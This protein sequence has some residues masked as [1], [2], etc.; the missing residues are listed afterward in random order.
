[1]LL[2]FLGSPRCFQQSF[3]NRLARFK[4]SKGAER[5]LASRTK[6]QAMLQQVRLATPEINMAP[7]R[8][9]LFDA[10]DDSLRKRRDM[11]RR[12]GRTFALG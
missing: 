9:F 10:I 3:S 8:G 2:A 11:N 5:S 1:M 12:N 7:Q 4:G 6:E